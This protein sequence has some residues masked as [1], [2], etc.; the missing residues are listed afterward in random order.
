MRQWTMEASRIGLHGVK[1]LM[2]PQK[3]TRVDPHGVEAPMHLAITMMEVGNVEDMTA[4][5]EAL[6]NLVIPMMTRVYQY[7][8]IV[9]YAAMCT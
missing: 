2:G 1:A 6:M 8:S 4:W 5:I 3:I 7:Y 9:F